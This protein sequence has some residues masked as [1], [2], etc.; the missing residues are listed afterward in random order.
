M[1]INYTRLFTSLGLL[2][3]A[4]NETNTWRGTLGTRRGT[5]NT[6]YVATTVY[7][8]LVS[9]LVTTLQS[10]KDAENSY[11]SALQAQALTCLIEEVT[12]DRPLATESLSTALAEL[13]RQMLISSQTLNDCPGTVTVASVGSPTGDPTFVFGVKEGATGLTTDYLVPDVYL[14]Q[15]SADR[16]NS[17]TAHGET[18]SLVGKPADAL[19]TDASYPSGTGLDTSVTVINPATDGGIVTN[20]GFD[21]WTVTNIPDDWTLR[22]GSVAG[23][24]VLKKTSD[25]PRGTDAAN[26]S[27][28]LVGDGTVIPG[29]RQEVTVTPNSV[30]SVYF[31]VKKVTDAGTDWAV[32]VRLTD[33]AGAALAGPGSYLNQVTTVTAGSV[34]ATWVNPTSGVFVI[35]ATLPTS[36]VFVEILFHQFG[37]VTIAPI[38]TSEVY[39]DHVSVQSTEPI[40][41]GGP[42]LTGFSGITES[43]LNDAR[44]ATVALTSGVPSTYL[45]RGVDRLLGLAGEAT[46]IPTVA[47]GGE[48]QADALVT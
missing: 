13:R 46:R 40:Y 43:V 6:N 28:R 33:G 44:T 2:A 41:D 30:Y 5:L 15:C 45:I 25:D 12:A 7:S 3:G 8:D 1:A 4:L 22:T 35:P 23:T 47:G 37:D 18:F 14:I 29:L 34:A 21:T 17:G 27:A 26:I 20:G 38:N 19:P 24:H 31:R 9:G 36:G 48:T 16:S 11:I 32:S 39:V 10:A 42:T